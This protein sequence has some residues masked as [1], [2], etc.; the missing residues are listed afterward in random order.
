MMHHRTKFD[1]SEVLFGQTFTGVLNLHCDLDL[2]YRKTTFSQDT[3][4]YEHVLSNQVGRQKISSSEHMIEIVMI[5]LY[6]PKLSYCDLDLEDSNPFFAH[7]TLAYNDV[8][9]YWVWLQMVH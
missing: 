6:E 2:E 8:T 5:S 3:P 7:D 1:R 9:P 4:A